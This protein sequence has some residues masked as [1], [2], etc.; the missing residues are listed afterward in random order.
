MELSE[1]AKKVLKTA[2]RYG[3][4]RAA[5][6]RDLI[7]PGDKDCSNMRRL[8]RGLVA[9]GLLRKYQPVMIDAL[10]GSAPPVF[11]LTLKGSSILAA[12]TGDK[13]DLIK[14]EVSFANNWIQ[15]NGW[16]GLSSVFMRID[17]AFVGQDH[18]KMTELHFEHEVK[19]PE[20]KDASERF[21]LQR[22]INRKPLVFCCPDAGFETELKVQTKIETKYVRRAWLNEFET[23]SD[24]PARC[25][26]KKAKG[27]AGLAEK[28]L[29]KTIFPLAEDFR[30]LALCPN[31]GWMNALREEMKKQPGNE[32]WL[33]A[34]AS[35]VTKEKFLHEPIL[36]TVGGTEPV[37]FVRRPVDYPAEGAVPGKAAGASERLKILSG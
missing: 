30:V 35:D 5:Q 7:N 32:F 16:I 6:F 11:T 34:S 17:S 18:V 27:Y 20:S 8:L 3:V 26:A 31:L 15:V 29:F 13:N 22:T 33:F 23:G 19:N 2:R 9:D 14:G 10:L 24:T 12:N 21:F 25:A 28:K 36:W 4:V 37:P 1:R